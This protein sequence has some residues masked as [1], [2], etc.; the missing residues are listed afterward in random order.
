MDAVEVMAASPL[1]AGIGPVAL[2][3]MAPAFARESWHKGHEIANPRECARRFHLIVK[4][5][6]KITRANPVDAREITLW[7]LGPGD[8]FDIVS[9]L[10]GEPHAVAAC[11]LDDVETFAVPLPV[12]QRWLEHSEPLRIAVHRYVA[13]QL[14]AITD[15]ASDLALYDTMT[16]LARLL[17]RHFDTRTPLR[18]ARVNLIR[19]LPQSELA[20]LIGSVRVVLGR[21]VAALKRERVVA[22][23]DGR[24]HVLDLKRLLRRAE[25]E[26][27]RTRHETRGRTAT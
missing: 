2:N 7:L 18:G 23:R 10:D 16:R 22:L 25:A 19:D 9:L 5:R 12:F 14:R 6:V 26:S 3:Q 21:L 13:Q 1:F 4:G 24:L 27:R 17:L 11:A 8:G 20:A 15:L